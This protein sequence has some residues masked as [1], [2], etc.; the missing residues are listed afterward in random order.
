MRVDARA[1]RAVIG[2]TKEHGAHNSLQASS[3]SADEADHHAAG[4][5]GIGATTTQTG[6]ESNTTTTQSSKK[7]SVQ[8][9]LEG[10]LSLKTPDIMALEADLAQRD[11]LFSYCVGVPKDAW[12]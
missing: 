1:A 2:H 5:G 11:L 7:L 10:E 9:L 12:A 3:A 8:A 4:G 6:Q